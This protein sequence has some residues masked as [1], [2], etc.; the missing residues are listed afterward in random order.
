MLGKAFVVMVGCEPQCLGQA[1]EALHDDAA[2]GL[3]TTR[4][5]GD[6][7]HQLERPFGRAE[8]GCRQGRVG[9]DHSDEPHSRE[10]QTL[11]GKNGLQKYLF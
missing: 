1:R 6:L 9:V 8:V 4:T 10:I 3:G 11:V 7:G 2:P 5:T